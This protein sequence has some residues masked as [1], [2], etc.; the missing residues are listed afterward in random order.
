MQPIEVRRLFVEGN[1]RR[2]FL[3][4]ASGLVI[5]EGC[6]Y[7]LADDEL[8]LGV[9]ARPETD[10]T[11]GR[12][13][14]LLPDEPELPADPERR[15]KKKP[16][17]EALVA[18]PGGL[19]ALGSG[20]RARRRRGALVPLLADEATGPVEVVD[21]APLYEKL[22]AEIDDLNIEGA[23][24]GS[25]TLTLLQRGN[26]RA[27]DN[28]LVELEAASV[29][30]ALAA[31]R[32]LPPS[33]LL[34]IHRCALGAL[35]G[36]ALSF[37]D[38][39]LLPDGRLL[40]A[41]AAEDTDDPYLDARCVGS[42]IGLFEAGQWRSQL[43]VDLKIE[44]LAIAG[45]QIWLVADADDPTTPAPLLVTELAKVAAGFDLQTAR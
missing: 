40:V 11:P 35:D 2:A 8:A 18:V 38:G 32:P 44:G 45:E 22:G 26:G 15:K 43:R 9:F 12:L 25:E 37:T 14:R 24:L 16:D 10:R 13:V 7:V 41:A 3:A 4:A 27:R 17:W 19:L 20:S 31:G 30:R 36:V 6:F 33:A 39:A 21:L 29:L 1:D 23:V 5:G 42:V 28:A 34:A